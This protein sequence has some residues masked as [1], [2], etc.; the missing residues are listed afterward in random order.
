MKDTTVSL[1]AGKNY[2]AILWGE[3]RLGTMKLTFVQDVPSDP[4]PQVALRVINTTGQ[5]DRRAP[6][7][8]RA[9]V[10]ATPTWASVPAYSFSSFVNV[11]VG[12]YRYN[13]RAAG[14]STNLIATDLTAL[15]GAP[16]DLVVGLEPLPGTTQAGSAVTLVVYPPSRRRRRGRRRA[17]H[18][19]LSAALSCGIAARISNRESAAPVRKSPMAAP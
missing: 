6:I 9:A 5:P 8:E 19:P 3:G 16:P 12:A 7:R 10:P 4:G 15:V 14:A 17:E 11:P 1:E 18:S 13:V 2:T